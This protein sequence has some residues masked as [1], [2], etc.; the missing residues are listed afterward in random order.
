M[1]ST[2]SELALMHS[3]QTMER[4][5]SAL[6]EKVVQLPSTKAEINLKFIFEPKVLDGLANTGQIIDLSSLRESA[7]S[8][9]TQ[10]NG[11]QVRS[12][13]YH[14]WDIFYETDVF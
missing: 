2:G 3:K 6:I 11:Q 9:R 10:Y 13:S 14:K 1:V 8:L 4:R 7:H 5:M 12:C